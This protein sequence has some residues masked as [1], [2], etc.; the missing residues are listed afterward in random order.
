MPPLRTRVESRRENQR[1]YRAAWAVFTSYAVSLMGA[2]AECDGNFLGFL[3]RAR[4]TPRG[5]LYPLGWRGH[6]TVNQSFTSS[7]TA[8]AAAPGRRAAQGRPSPSHSCATAE[9]R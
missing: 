8:A 7:P 6:E 3:F 2:G 9:R 1:G 5:M 4:A